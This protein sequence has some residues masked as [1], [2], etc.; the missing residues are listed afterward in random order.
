MWDMIILTIFYE[1]GEGGV[2][3]VGNEYSNYSLEG[4]CKQQGWRPTT[5]MMVLY[6]P[7]SVVKILFIV[8][9]QLKFYNILQ[10]TLFIIILYSIKW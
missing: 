3:T 6:W 7:D 10:N 9:M 4:E 1:Q 5:R 2:R 8:D